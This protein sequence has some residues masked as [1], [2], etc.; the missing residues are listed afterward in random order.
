[1]QFYVIWKFGTWGGVMICSDLLLIVC[2][3]G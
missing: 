1:M 2:V 3:C